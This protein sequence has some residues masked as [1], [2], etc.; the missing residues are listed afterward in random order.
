MIN[1]PSA[2]PHPCNHPGCSTLTN[3]RYCPKHTELHKERIRRYESSRGTAA[4]RG[5][6]VRW[7][8]A[9]RAYLAK[10]PWCVECG[11]EGIVKRATDVHHK[12]PHKGNYELFWDENNWVSLCHSCHSKISAWGNEMK[13]KG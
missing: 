10:H 13:Q 9:R 5:Y 4:A 1:V 3:Q 2:P 7:S 12:T 11:K 6:D 8:R